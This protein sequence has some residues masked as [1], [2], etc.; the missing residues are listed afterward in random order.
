MSC[1]DIG[2]GCDQL[3]DPPSNMQNLLKANDKLCQVL[4]N[5]CLSCTIVAQQKSTP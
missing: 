2:S 1:V 3:R 4:L 5:G